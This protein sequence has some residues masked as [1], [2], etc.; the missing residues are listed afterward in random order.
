[1]IPPFAGT[2]RPVAGPRVA[3]TTAGRPASGCS[4]VSNGAVRPMTCTW[5]IH[6]FSDE[7]I[8]QLYIGPDIDDLGL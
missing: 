5:S 2:A 6:A 8:D 1:V 7:G 4:F 3:T